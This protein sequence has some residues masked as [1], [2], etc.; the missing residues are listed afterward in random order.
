ME[1]SKMNNRLKKD[2]TKGVSGQSVVVKR[3]PFKIGLSA[4]AREVLSKYTMEEIMQMQIADKA[5]KE[6]EEGS[7]NTRKK[8]RK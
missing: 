3:I 6:K 8:K 4:D 2:S 5:Q 1:I 7:K